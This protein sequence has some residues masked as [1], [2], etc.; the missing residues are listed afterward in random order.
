MNADLASLRQPV[1]REEVDAV[2]IGG[3]Y[4]RTR[5]LLIANMGALTL[6]SIS[7]WSAGNR[8]HVMLWA[9]TLAS[10]TMLRFALAKVYLSRPRAIGE[11]RKWTYAFSVGSGVAGLLWGSSLF[12]IQHLD[13][14]KGP[15]VTAFLM[16]ALSAAAIAGYT[17]SLIAFAAFI[18]PSLVPFGIHLVFMDGTPHL[19]IAGFVL[20]WAW[21][22]WSMAR[23][24]NEGFKDG[25]RLSL[26]NQ[27]L[28]ERL[29]REKDKA[30]AANL[31][32]TRFLGN[33]S[34][35][36]RTPLN[37]IVGYSEMM[38]LGVLGPLGELYQNYAKDIHVSGQHL[39]G[40]IDNMLDVSKFDSG[41]VDLTE[42]N[43][44]IADLVS[45]A[46][47]FVAKNA[48]D[49]RIAIHVDLEKNLPLIRGDAARLRQVM[50]NLLS[51]AVKFTPP[52]GQIMIAADRVPA[53]AA[54]MPGGI[55][56]AIAD[57]GIGIAP[58]DIEH[59]TTPFR[60]LEHQD[61]L[62]RVTPLKQTGP[63]T[64]AGLGLPLAR[65]L[66]ELHGGSFDVES[67][68]GLGTTVSLRL[69]QDRVVV[70]Q[71]SAAY[72]AAAE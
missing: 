3:L 48:A 61:H 7:L 63:H 72:R 43:I 21:L 24:L 30:E 36:L 45:S 44:D 64:T 35:E 14:A 70:P 59:L 15:L 5:P 38:S 65:L 39:L 60:R 16:A 18:T 27:H 46:V 33:M 31:A 19:M 53:D 68:P 23:H 22:V 57:T 54:E 13:P 66:T 17:N 52:Q 34:H 51:N 26:Q 9:L 67:R 12:L 4:R 62:N 32:K 71:A 55:A 41:K 69:P 8:G 47:G 37:A 1:S 42:D 6:L 25:I 11:A 20:F 29:A 2:L 49:D 40:M 10:W 58:Q 50:V 28:A 56:I